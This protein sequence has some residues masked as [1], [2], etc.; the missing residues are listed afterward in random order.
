MIPSDKQKIDDLYQGDVMSEEKLSC[1]TATETQHREA[2]LFCH[3][4]GW[5]DFSV[6][7]WWK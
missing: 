2:S 3:E 6:P 4:R 5:N 1:A 7:R